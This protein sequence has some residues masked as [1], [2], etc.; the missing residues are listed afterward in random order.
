MFAAFYK[1]FK[2]PANIYSIDKY[3]DHDKVCWL[4]ITMKE[5]YT[6]K[7]SDDESM[8]VSCEMIRDPYKTNG[9]QTIFNDSALD[10]DNVSCKT[11]NLRSKPAE[12]IEALQPLSFMWVIA[13]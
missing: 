13:R 9:K 6:L 3:K 4:I 2:S 7:R 10:C 1:S 12:G 8:Q 11:F 5:L